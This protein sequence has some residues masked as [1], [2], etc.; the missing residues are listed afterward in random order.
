MTVK[1]QVVETDIR[2]GQD[3]EIPY[4]LTTTPWGSDPTDV[5][6]KAYD[7]GASYTD[8]TS[9]VLEGSS[10]VSGDVITTPVLKSLTIGKD[11]RIEIQ[12]VTGA[13]TLECFFMVH[14]ER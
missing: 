1:L 5:I 8:V 7:A 2:Q 4:A 6:I 3:E 14:G 11:Y 10:S 9:T 12:F 13:K